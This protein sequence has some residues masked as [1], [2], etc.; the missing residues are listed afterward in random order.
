MTLNQSKMIRINIYIQLS[1]APADVLHVAVEAAFP[2]GTL[3]TDQLAESK[4]WLNG[5]NPPLSLFPG[6]FPLST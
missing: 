6:H 3:L 4:D 1:Y 5:C 2:R